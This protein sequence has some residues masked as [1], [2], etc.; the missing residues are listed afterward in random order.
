MSRDAYV[1][2]IAPGEP[3][4]PLAFLFHG[5]GGSEDQLMDLGRD[6]MPG[7][8]LVAP[9]GDVDEHGALRFFRRMGEGRYD[10]ADLA[11]ATAKTTA[12]VAAHRAEH[13]D[14]RVVGV[15][16]SNG[17]NILGN[18]IFGARDLFDDAVLMH[19]LIAWE[20]AAGPVR[21]RVLITAGERDPICPAPL[22]RQLEGWFR[23]QGAPVETLWHPGGHGIEVSE[24]EAARRFLAQGTVVTGGRAH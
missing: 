15:G 11:R 4:A 3:G 2:K 1:H 10:M 7:A 23:A 24:I 18:V 8:T 5:T 9:R 13:P 19:P 6:L 16:Y 17:A 14:A 21:T 12:F 22:T 20:P